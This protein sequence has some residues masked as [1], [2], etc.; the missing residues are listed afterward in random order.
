M[1][2]SKTASTRSDMVWFWLL[3]LLLIGA[4]GLGQLLAG[5]SWVGYLQGFTMMF[6]SILL[7]ALPFVLLGTLVSSFIHLRLDADTLAYLLP[8]NH[9]FG[10]CAA[11][12]LGFL[13]PVCECAIV[14]ITRGL[15]R[16]GVPVGMAV[17]FLLA[18]PIVNPIVLASTYYAFNG[19]WGVVLLRAICGFLVAVF[20]GDY[21]GTVFKNDSPLRDKSYY[22]SGSVHHEADCSHGHSHGSEHSA[23]GIGQLLQHTSEEFFSVG[24]YLIIG[25]ALSAAVQTLV[26]RQWLAV[27]GQNSLLSVIA[28]MALAYGLSLCSEAD[29]FIARTFVGHFSGGSI[30]AFLVLGPML[31]LK[32][33]LLLSGACSGPFVRRL[34]LTVTLAVLGLGLL[35]NGFNL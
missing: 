4:P 34:A 1:Y 22:G 28:L 31:D 2:M 35:A 16:K 27:V 19:A 21:L 33:T 9:R 14:P 11:A 25:A 7:E 32:G 6:I 20:V 29:A 24:R 13:F 18:V 5:V 26:P 23:T 17:A 10:T 30:L 12:L 8:K 15:L 3:L